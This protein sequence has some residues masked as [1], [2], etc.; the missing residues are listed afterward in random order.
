VLRQIKRDAGLILIYKQFLKLFRN[1]LFPGYVI[2]FGGENKK[3]DRFIHSSVKDTVIIHE[4]EFA[5]SERLADS[6]ICEALNRIISQHLEFVLKQGI[7]G[8]THVKHIQI[9]AVVILK[10]I[11]T[12]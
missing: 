5:F 4:D 9:V 1:K 10:I 3:M 11:E 12:K 6:K 2:D 8:L 7:K